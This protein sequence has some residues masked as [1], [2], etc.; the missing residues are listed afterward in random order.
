MG[1]A[2]VLGFWGV[3]V[4][5]WGFVWLWVGGG[6]EGGG[7]AGPGG[8]AGGVSG[9]GTEGEAEAAPLSDSATV[10]ACGLAQVGDGTYANTLQCSRDQMCVPV[11]FMLLQGG[12]VLCMAQGSV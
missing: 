7:G 11:I 5:G 3:F 12:T 2:V 4:C 1:V 9:T 10:A 6:G 8:G